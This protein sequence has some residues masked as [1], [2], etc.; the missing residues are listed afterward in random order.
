MH[1]SRTATI[2]LVVTDVAATLGTH[3]LATSAAQVRKVHS[4]ITLLIEFKSDDDECTLG[5]DN[6]AQY[7]HDTPGS[8]ICSC[9]LGYTLA[10]N[11]YTCNGISFAAIYSF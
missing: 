7:C 6:C 10:A 1:V 9:R 4:T 2:L 8:Y 5:S 11:G 3:S